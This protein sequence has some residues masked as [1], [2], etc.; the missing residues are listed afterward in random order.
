MVAHR[1]ISLE[2]AIVTR[3]GRTTRHDGSN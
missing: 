3:Y 1:D 2:D